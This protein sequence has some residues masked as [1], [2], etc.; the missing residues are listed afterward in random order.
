M[1]HF[2][3]HLG[4][5][6]DGRQGC[7]RSI[8]SVRYP[9]HYL[10]LTCATPEA[11]LAC[12]EALLDECEAGD[13]PAVLRF[14][15]PSEPF[16]VVGYGSRVAEEVNLANCQRLGVPVLRRC[17]GGGAVLQ[18]PG[19]LNYT[20]VL[21]IAADSRLA[22]IPQTNRFILDRHA[23]TLTQLLGQPV[24]LEGQT[25][26]ALGDLKCS[27]NAQRRRSRA[28][29]FHGTFLFGLDAALMEAVLRLPSRQP[30]YRQGRS[31]K[32]FVTQLPL[33]AQAIKAALRQCWA[34]DRPLDLV[35][36]RAI[37]ALV[38]SRY[39]RPEWTFRS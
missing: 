18:G 24:R 29:L 22:A 32:D 30:A 36:W 26:L 12:D 9:V 6:Y 34:A 25:D 37:E 3:V 16:V 35:P 27:G 11:N 33:S 5:P 10:E 39:A 23:Q 21:P 8:Q 4:L 1:H 31:H 15:E 2:P 14:W 19:C 38:Q 7:Y 20:L 17:T 13:G 28:V